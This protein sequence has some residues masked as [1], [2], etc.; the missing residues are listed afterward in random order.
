M[1]NQLLAEQSQAQAEQKKEEDKSIAE[2]KLEQIKEPI[3]LVGAELLTSGINGVGSYLTKK[4]GIQAFQSMGENIKKNGF[5][6]GFNDTLGKARKEIGSKGSKKLN[7]ALNQVENKKKDIQKAVTNKVQDVKDEAQ[8][9]KSKAEKQ[10]EAGRENF[11]RKIN[12]KLQNQ[13]KKTLKKI[14]SGTNLKSKIQEAQQSQAGSADEPSGITKGEQEQI[15]Q[16]YLEDVRQG[17]I[18]SKNPLQYTP[19]DEELDD[20]GLFDKLKESLK[21]APTFEESQKEFD[22]FTNKPVNRA[23]TNKLIE[24]E[25]DEDD[26]FYPD[27]SVRGDKSI[28]DTLN[29]N[30]SMG[31]QRSYL[32]SQLKLTP[33][34]LP[35]VD[36]DFKQKRIT[37]TE[38]TKQRNEELQKLKEVTQKEN[39]KKYGTELPDVE[40]NIQTKIEALDNIPNSRE[41]HL[42]RKQQ[43]IDQLEQKQIQEPVKP[44]PEN[45]KPERM[46]GSAEEYEARAKELEK[47]PFDPVQFKKDLAEKAKQLD[48]DYPETKTPSLLEDIPEQGEDLLGATQGRVRTGLLDDFG[49]K[50]VVPQPQVQAQPPPDPVS[51]KPPSTETDPALTQT[52]TQTAEARTIIEPKKPPVEPIE[53]DEAGSG[54]SKGLG[55]ASIDTE[56]LG[57]GPE[58]PISDILSLGLGIGSLIASAFEKPHLN[59]SWTPTLQSSLQVGTGSS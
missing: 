37:Q 19:N 38:L 31:Q 50:P 8:V 45:P 53:E 10:L 6:K 32:Q 29:E 35:D 41:K 57:G 1:D 47:T 58:D 25:F 39:I 48:I 17:K 43:V 40:P 16:Q 49:D 56:E 34:K 46:G 13:G 4:T 14:T 51:T 18:S 42:A 36:F 26:L 54:L 59:N 22:P 52:E 55:E 27:G 7:D 3:Q 20:Q 28:A 44:N 24:P 12:S 5:E 11:R 33:E 9:F 2:Q 23:K 21:P 30:F 15:K